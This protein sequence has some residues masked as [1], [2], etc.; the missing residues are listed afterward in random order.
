MK[1]T[2]LFFFVV[3]DNSKSNMHLFMNQSKSRE[4][5]RHFFCFQPTH[6]EKT[7]L[8][9]SWSGAVLTKEQAE[10]SRVVVS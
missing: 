7:T 10:E 4:N 9:G 1:K 2:V 5:K 3:L 8:F 6:Q